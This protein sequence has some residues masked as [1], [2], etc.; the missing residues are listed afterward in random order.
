[1]SDTP[2]D[3]Q[4]PHWRL[5]HNSDAWSKILCSSASTAEALCHVAVAD[6]EAVEDADWGVKSEEINSLI[7]RRS[8]ARPHNQWETSS[9]Q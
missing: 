9:P 1:M 8:S 5:Q 2:F 3:M 6:S 7:T 4:D